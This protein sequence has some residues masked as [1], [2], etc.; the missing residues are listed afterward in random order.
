MSQGVNLVSSVSQ[1]LTGTKFSFANYLNQNLPCRPAQMSA[2]LLDRLSQFL[3]LSMF[4]N[5]AR[6]QM[7]DSLQTFLGQTDLHPS[8]QGQDDQGRP[9]ALPYDL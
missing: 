5:A 1:N 6:E 9:A 8:C 4:P 7:K 3:K 2:F